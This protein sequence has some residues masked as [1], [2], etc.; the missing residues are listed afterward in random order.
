MTKRYAHLCTITCDVVNTGKGGD[1]LIT[2]IL[3]K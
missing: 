3:K 1:W 2:R